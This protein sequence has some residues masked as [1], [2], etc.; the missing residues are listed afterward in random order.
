MKFK[1]LKLCTYCSFS[2]RSS[3][4]MR[5]SSSV[6][7]SSLLLGFFWHPMFSIIKKNCVIA[8]HAHTWYL[9]SPQML[10]ECP[11]FIRASFLFLKFC[12]CYIRKRSVLYM[13]KKK[14]LRVLTKCWKWLSSEK[15]LIWLQC[16]K[17]TEEYL[18]IR[19]ILQ[20]RITSKFRNAMKQAA[21]RPSV[22]AWCPLS[23]LWRHQ[24]H[25]N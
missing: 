24:H 7:L 19:L 16:S 13:K 21:N 1:I 22:V 2:L 10:L 17:G 20:T 12:W 15:S 23:L 11:I 4:V 8:M 5:W 6:S 9:I 14:E 3:S 25:L 18:T